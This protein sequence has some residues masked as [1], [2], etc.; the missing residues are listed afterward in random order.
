[1]GQQNQGAIEIICE[2][3]AGI[4]IGGDFFPLPTPHQLRPLQ[5][6]Q[7]LGELRHAI[8]PPFGLQPAQRAHRGGHEQ[9]RRNLR[10]S[11]IAQQA[12]QV[13]TQVEFVIGGGGTV[14]L[15]R[16][17]ETAGLLGGENKTEQP[18]DPRGIQGL[19][20]GRPNLGQQMLDAGI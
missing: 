15:F 5:I 13:S 7:Q 1:M 18:L 6:G 14:P 16:H 10:V 9:L 11:G 20:G 3:S 12:L 2:I 19:L 17:I 4:E 8:A